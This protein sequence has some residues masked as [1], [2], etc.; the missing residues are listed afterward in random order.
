VRS[1]EGRPELK[2]DK[3]VKREESALDVGGPYADREPDGLA[4][5]EGRE[6]RRVGTRRPIAGGAPGKTYEFKPSQLCV[7]WTRL[8]KKA[9]GK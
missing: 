1:A 6:G 4:E 3:V 7:L 5:L 8:P 9:G 2:K